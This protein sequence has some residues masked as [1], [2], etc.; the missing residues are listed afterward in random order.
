MS[1]MCIKNTA[2]LSVSIIAF[3]CGWFVF[4][5]TTSLPVVGSESTDKPSQRRPECRLVLIQSG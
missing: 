5:S 3:I 2:W 1:I 4:T